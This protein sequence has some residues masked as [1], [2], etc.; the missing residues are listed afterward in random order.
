MFSYVL[1]SFIAIFK[2]KNR[3]Y[4]SAKGWKHNSKW[5]RKPNFVPIHFYSLFVAITKLRT[6]AKQ[7]R[8]KNNFNII[9]LLKVTSMTITRIHSKD[10]MLSSNTVNMPF[11]LSLIIYLTHQAVLWPPYKGIHLEPPHPCTHIG[12]AK[13]NPAHTAI[14]FPAP[15][16]TCQEEIGYQ[17]S[18]QKSISRNNNMTTSCSCLCSCSPPE[19]SPLI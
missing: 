8:K 15:S 2:M 11:F 10:R 6:R 3:P 17:M 9:F 7:W 16:R 5:Y 1:C 13:W 19:S 14:L 18:L 12:I 4:Q